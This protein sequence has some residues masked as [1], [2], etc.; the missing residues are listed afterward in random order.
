M[1]RN[2]CTNRSSS[3]L[4]S[5]EN[6]PMA[7]CPSA[8]GG[9]LLG[10]TGEPAPRF[11]STIAD[12]HR[13]GPVN[14]YGGNFWCFPRFPQPIATENPTSVLPDGGAR[15]YGCTGPTNHRCPHAVEPRP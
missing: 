2:V 4:I 5:L 6:S 3:V 8:C 11:P 10:G 1:S 13:P 12:A 7:H 14:P 9:S 15:P